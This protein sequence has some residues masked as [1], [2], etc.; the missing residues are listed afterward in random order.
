MFQNIVALIQKMLPR[1]S[2]PNTYGAALEAWIVSQ[3]PQ[4]PGD[5]D[6]LVREFDRRSQS[7]WPA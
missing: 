3:N 4:S 5:I 2:Q 7:G 6:R 1:N